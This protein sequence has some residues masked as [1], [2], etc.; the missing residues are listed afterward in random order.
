LKIAKQILKIFSVPRKR[1]FGRINRK[2]IELPKRESAPAVMSESKVA[3][4]S[5]IGLV[6]IGTDC[7]F[8]G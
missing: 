3:E 6:I 7:S 4:L 5:Q 1:N 8:V 2:S